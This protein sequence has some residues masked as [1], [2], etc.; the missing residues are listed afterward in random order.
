MDNEGE[1]RFTAPDL[2]D[3]DTVTKFKTAAQITNA[4]LARVVQLCQP[5]A[6]IAEI[7]DAG[8]KL[9]ADA[10]AKVYAKARDVDGEPLK[11]SIGFPT[12]VTPNNAVG[13][14]SPLLSNPITLQ[15]GDLIKIS[16]GAQIDGLLASATHSMIVTSA[17][18]AV[19]GPKADV[20][21]AAH[22]ASQAALRLLRPGR[23][24][25]EVTAAIASVAADFGCKPVQGV[26]SHQQ[27]RFKPRSAKKIL[28]RAVDAGERPPETVVFEEGQ[29]WEVC[30]T[31][32]TGQGVVSEVD[33]RTTVFELDHDVKY[34][35]SR[36]SS[37][38][39]YHAIKTNCPDF[40]FSLRTL[41]D[42]KHTRMGITELVEH[43]MVIPHPVTFDKKDELVAQF[44]FTTLILPS[45]IDQLTSHA[46]PFVQSSLEVTDPKVKQVLSMGLGRKKPN[47][48]R[49][50]KKT[51]AP[52]AGMDTTTD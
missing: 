51:A 21:C 33:Q 8:D 42:E 36:K 46:L 39:V 38:A 9:L 41:G 30:V 31:M 15:E 24:S 43:E 28:N 19:T 20:I 37:R 17:P 32:S 6:R 16:L 10:T 44:R 7:C 13:N 22:F 27:L 40:P 34:M 49:N 25:D 18:V 48:K 47:K 3:P 29:V 11:R 4:V 26:D 5:G 35:L 2:S 45:C 14:F 23:N 12:C 50:K 52:A 1:D